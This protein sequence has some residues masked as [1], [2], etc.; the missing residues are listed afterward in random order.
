MLLSISFFVYFPQMLL[1]DIKE[2]K[3]EMENLQEQG[4]ALQALTHD[5]LIG[6]T[7]SQSCTKY[8]TL[9]NGCMVSVVLKVVGIFRSSLVTVKVLHQDLIL[10][11]PPPQ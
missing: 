2:H 1:D 4:S 6:S 3:T 10:Y 9:Q 5:P 8:Q 11:N 7:V